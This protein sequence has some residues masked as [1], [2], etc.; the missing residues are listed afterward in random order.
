MPRKR[1]TYSNEFKQEMV[2]LYN[3]GNPRTQL[4]REYELIPSALASWI[5]NQFI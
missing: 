2:E 1:R 4:I 3:S 5:S